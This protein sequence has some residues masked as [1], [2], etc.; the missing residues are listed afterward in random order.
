MS[1]SARVRRFFGDDEY[2]FRLGIG[3]AE[4]VD[5]ET[6]FGLMQLLERLPLMHVAELRSVLRNGLI[7]GGMK[8]QEAWALVKRHLVEGYLVEA[9]DVATAV[10]VAC[11]RGVPDDPPDIG[12]GEPQGEQ[13]S[14]IR[15]PTVE[16]ASA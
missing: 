3:E 6:G 15:S 13:T 16:S 2:D 1:R 9:T 5:E 4:T 7:G 8:R 11:I 14:P 12:V 10:L